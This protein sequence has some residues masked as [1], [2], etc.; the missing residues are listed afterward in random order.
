MGSGKTV[1]AFLAAIAA[2]E[3]GCQAALMA[4]TELLAEQHARTLA[5]L[6][7]QEAELHALRDELKTCMQL[8]GAQN[9]AQID[10]TFIVRHGK[11]LRTPSLHRQGPRRIRRLRTR[12]SEG[13]RSAKGTSS[14]R[15]HSQ[16]SR[17]TRLDERRGWMLSLP[18]CT[19]ALRRLL[20]LRKAA[21][22]QACP[23][24]PA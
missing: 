21:G 18:W 19:S 9:V 15:V 14:N 8:G 3:T 23:E 6:A 24:C 1:V 12:C 20:Q 13:C 4:P 17:A 16:L 10:R 2:A 22:Q 7:A 11:E 5:A